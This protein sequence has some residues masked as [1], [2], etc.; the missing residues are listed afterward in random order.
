VSSP[1]RTIELALGP[2]VVL[3]A[4][5]PRAVPFLVVG[6]LLIGGLV[7]QGVLG[8]VLLGVLALLMAILLFLAWPA[9]PSQA[10]VLR[11]AVLLLVLVRAVSVLP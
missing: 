10:R 1:R 4:Q 6:G 5:L 9:L 8:A 2:L 3:L 7:A 11:L